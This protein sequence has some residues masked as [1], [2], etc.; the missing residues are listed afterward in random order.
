MIHIKEEIDEQY[1]EYLQNCID[2]EDFEIS[3]VE[4]YCTWVKTENCLCK[5][6]K[7]I[8]Q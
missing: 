4:D 2:D 6:C 3:H 1:R 7:A 8:K 5:T